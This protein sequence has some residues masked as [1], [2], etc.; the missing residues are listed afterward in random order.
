MGSTWGQGPLGLFAETKDSSMLL[1]NWCELRTFWKTSKSSRERKTNTIKEYLWIHAIIVHGVSNSIAE[2]PCKKEFMSRGRLVFL[3]RLSI[4]NPEYWL[5][6][7]GGFLC[8]GWNLN[9]SWLKQLSETEISIS[10]LT[11]SFLRMIRFLCFF[12]RKGSQQLTSSW[13]GLDRCESSAE[14]FDFKWKNCQAWL[15]ALNEK[16]K[17]EIIFFFKK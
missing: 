11:P 13:K 6:L 17:S 15:L 8:F 2:C 5:T 1:P 4:S 12:V 14:N 9:L 7:R 16:W 3:S 10:D